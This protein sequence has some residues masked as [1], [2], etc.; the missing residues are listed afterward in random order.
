MTVRSE[1]LVI[2]ALVIAALFIA[3]QLEGVDMT[4]VAHWLAATKLT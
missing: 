2:S 1:L 4:A 3:R